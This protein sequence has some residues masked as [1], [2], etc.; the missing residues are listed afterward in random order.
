M[1]PEYA[2]SS[3]QRSG[4]RTGACADALIQIVCQDEFELEAIGGVRQADPRSSLDHPQFAAVVE[5]AE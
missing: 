4:R 1:T 5:H 2:D 3:G